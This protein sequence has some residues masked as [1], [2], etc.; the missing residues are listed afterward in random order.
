MKWLLFLAALSPL[1]A[2]TISMSTGELRLDGTH[3]TYELKMPSYELVDIRNPEQVLFDN[4][5]FAEGTL[6]GKVCNNNGAYLTCKATYEFPRVMD[7]VEI[8]CRFARV[9]VQ[10]HIHLL[11]AYLGDKSDQAIFDFTVEKADLRF[12]PP[13]AF[14]TA[15]RESFEGILRAA[16]SVPGLLF[17][18][19]LALAARSW[20]EMG[21]LAL[22]FIC[23]EVAACIAMPLSKFDPSLRF[24]EAALALTVAYLAV[25]ILFLPAAGSR[26]AVAGVLGVFHGLYFAIFLRDSEYH[27][28][29]VLGGVIGVEL[30]A[31]AALSWVMRK[32]RPVH[33]YLAMVL[34]A[35]GMGW[36]G[37]RMV[38]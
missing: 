35:V 27:A 33:R 25:E 21:L 28:R 22:S 18:I 12:R 32:I 19:A 13:T 38:R 16:T 31:L 26:W 10:N 14:E 34:L 36:F 30:V 11:H 20:S 6:T 1:A 17:L 37:L 9:T 3:A 23:G 8:E 5:K 15:V 4:I 29:Y 24:I 7:S 2:H